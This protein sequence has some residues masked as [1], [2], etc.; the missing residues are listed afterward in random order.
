MTL[1]LSDFK[2]KVLSR[3]P[4]VKKDSYNF[5]LC[6]EFIHLDVCTQILID[7]TKSKGNKKNRYIGFH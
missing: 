3:V 1:I 2:Y 7:D 6:M 5:A 4:F